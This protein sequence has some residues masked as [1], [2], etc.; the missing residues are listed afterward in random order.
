MHLTQVKDAYDKGFFHLP[1]QHKAQSDILLQ[2]EFSITPTIKS[3]VENS[4]ELTD[5][6]NSLLAIRVREQA[7]NDVSVDGK[8]PHF[9]AAIQPLFRES[10]RFTLPPLRSL[11]AGNRRAPLKDNLTSY[12]QT[13]PTLTSSMAVTMQAALLPIGAT[14]QTHGS[15]LEII[16]IKTEE[17]ATVS[18][19]GAT[20]L[21]SI[22]RQ[23][24]RVWYAVFA[25]KRFRDF[26]VTLL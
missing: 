2:K 19:Q 9:E 21:P 22:T 20:V 10:N 5:K 3:P 12:A 7:S 25:S 13:C 11:S 15:C 4:E 14:L 26:K 16:R 6:A 8:P 1:V 18:R 24:K 23:K 17:R